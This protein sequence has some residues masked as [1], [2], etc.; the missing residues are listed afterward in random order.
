MVYAFSL[1]GSLLS[2][3]PAVA[4]TPGEPIRSVATLD[5]QVV[6]EA[7]V[8][9]T[10]PSPRTILQGVAGRVEQAGGVKVQRSVERSDGYVEMDVTWYIPED[11]WPELQEWLFAN[12]DAEF[13]TSEYEPDSS[14]EAGSRVISLLVEA[15]TPSEPV[16]YLQIGPS[17]GIAYPAAGPGLGL[18]QPIGVRAMFFRDFSL[19][20]AVSTVW[21]TQSKE[22]RKV[23][24]I[25][26]GG[27]PRQD[28][29][30]RVREHQVTA[31][32]IT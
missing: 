20:A 23:K 8:T 1:L 27:L 2:T 12:Y 4:D 5:G 22:N 18:A 31:R 6:A 30:R 11:N 14:G 16:A 25:C 7:W 21:L 13:E 19:D 26:R 24:V 9:V 10:D 29:A 28:A 15:S 17:A 32:E 3:S